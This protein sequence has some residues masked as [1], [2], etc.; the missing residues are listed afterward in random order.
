MAEK[1]GEFFAQNW[2]AYSSSVEKEA[3]NLNLNFWTRVSGMKLYSLLKGE[4]VG[5]IHW[6]SEQLFFKHLG[7]KIG[8]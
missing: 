2:V 3:H 4:W 1:L 8:S 5:L 6:K 7:I